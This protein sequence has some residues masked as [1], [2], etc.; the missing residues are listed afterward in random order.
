[1]SIAALAFAAL[2]AGSQAAPQTPPSPD[3][4]GSDGCGYRPGS[5]R[6]VRISYAVFDNDPPP[7]ADRHG[8]AYRTADGWGPLSDT[9]FTAAEGRDWFVRNETITVEGVAYRKYGFPRIYGPEEFAFHAEYDDV[10]VFEEAETSDSPYAEHDHDGAT[11][12]HGR[13][14]VLLNPAGCEFQPYQAE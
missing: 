13:I 1:M 4:T 2:L 14:F 5:G 3:R 11:A 6:L 9:P 10:G 12:P 8:N 7:F